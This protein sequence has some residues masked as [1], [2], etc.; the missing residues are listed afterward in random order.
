MTSDNKEVWERIL[1]PL[2]RSSG[3]LIFHYFRDDENR[4]VQYRVEYDFETDSWIVAK[5]SLPQKRMNWGK[6]KINMARAEKELLIQKV[7]GS[8]KREFHSMKEW[9]RDKEELT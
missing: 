2:R 4:R 7:I 8:I 6:I 3:H 9:V 1:N 5:F